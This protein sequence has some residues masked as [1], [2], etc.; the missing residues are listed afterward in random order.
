MDVS[1]TYIPS[2][3]VELMRKGIVSKKKHCIVE[4]DKS[5]DI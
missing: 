3:V 2:V 1:S 5:K 4:Y